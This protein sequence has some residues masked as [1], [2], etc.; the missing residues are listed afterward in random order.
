MLGDELAEGVALEVEHPRQ[1]VAQ[2]RGEA[3]ALGQLE[4]TEVSAED[5]EAARAGKYRRAEFDSARW[6]QARACS[7]TSPEPP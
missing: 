2:R 6:V 3:I 1:R 4:V 7:N 5:V